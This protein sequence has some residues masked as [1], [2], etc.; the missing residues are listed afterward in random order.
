MRLPVSPRE[1][2]SLALSV[3]IG[4]LALLVLFLTYSLVDRHILRPPVDT[5]RQGTSAGGVIQIDILNGCG[6]AG[7]ATSVRDYLRARGFDVVEMRNYKSF[8]VEHSLVVDRTG[9]SGN[10]ERVAY[11][12]GIDRSRIIQ[13]INTDYFVDVSVV[14][15]RDHRTLKP[16]QEK[17]EHR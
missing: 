8:D 17:G 6:V 3:L 12:L 10:A 7:A 5:A 13:Q 4:A 2:R 9:A 11:A 14:V 16:S 15:G 1:P